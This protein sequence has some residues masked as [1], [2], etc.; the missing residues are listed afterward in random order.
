MF[1]PFHKHRVCFRFFAFVWSQLRYVARPKLTCSFSVY[2]SGLDAI[3]LRAI[4]VNFIWTVARWHRLDTGD[5]FSVLVFEIRFESCVTC[6]RCNCFQWLPI[7][8]TKWTRSEFASLPGCC[9]LASSDCEPITCDAACKQ[10]WSRWQNGHN[11]PSCAFKSTCW[12]LWSSSSSS[13][14]A[15]WALAGRAISASCFLAIF[16]A[17]SFFGWPANYLDAD[18]AESCVEFALRVLDWGRR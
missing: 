16:A 15:W 2:S 18:K 13:S 17:S 12:C 14:S 1:W 7:K 9:N 4:N 3:G 10:E 8:Q 6:C 11:F 5:Y